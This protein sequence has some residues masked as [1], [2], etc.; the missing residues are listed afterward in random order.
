MSIHLDEWFLLLLH[1]LILWSLN[2]PP[3]SFNSFIDTVRKFR[4]IRYSTSN[5]FLPK[6]VTGPLS[7]LSAFVKEKRKESKFNFFFFLNK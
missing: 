6:N 4:K 3:Y 2:W 1:S 5:Y 7:E